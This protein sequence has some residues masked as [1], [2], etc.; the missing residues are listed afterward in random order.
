[1]SFS[2]IDSSSR[3]LVSTIDIMFVPHLPWEDLFALV[4]DDGLDTRDALDCETVS[5]ESVEAQLAEDLFEADRIAD[6]HY[7]PYEPEMEWED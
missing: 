3:L 1:M 2:I 7:R 4:D 5:F 6:G